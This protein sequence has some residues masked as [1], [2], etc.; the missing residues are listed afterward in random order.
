MDLLGAIHRA[1]GLRINEAAAALRVAPNTVSTLVTRLVAA[2]HVERDVDP[3]DG[4]GARLSLTASTCHRMEQ[5]RGRR[6]TTL[7]RAMALLDGEEAA[8]LIGALPVLRRLVDLV[9]QVPDA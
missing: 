1:P 4:R 5:W 7:D 2:G 3:T 9:D 6:E 8:L